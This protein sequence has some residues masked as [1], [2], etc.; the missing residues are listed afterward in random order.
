MSLSSD[1]VALRRK[2]TATERALNNADPLVI[3][4]KAHQA[5]VTHSKSN[6]PNNSPIVSHFFMLLNISW[7][8][9]QMTNQGHH[10]SVHM[11]DDD[12]LPTEVGPIAPTKSGMTSSDTQANTAQMSA[13][14]VSWIFFLY[15]K[16]S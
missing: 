14:S 9:I 1:S 7:Y 3:K 5:G 4:K 15:E 8:S 11:Q 13:P 10:A 12:D 6:P 16:L 2:R